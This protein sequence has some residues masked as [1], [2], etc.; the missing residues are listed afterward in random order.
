MPRD[1][2]LQ[3]LTSTYC[4]LYST[5]HSMSLVVELLRQSIGAMSAHDKHCDPQPARLTILH[6]I[7]LSQVYVKHI[8]NMTDI[9]EAFDI[10]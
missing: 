2:L 1:S 7:L 3:T 10:Q 9:C 4:L 5:V 8:R 6:F